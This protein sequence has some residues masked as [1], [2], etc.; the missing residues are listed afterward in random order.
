MLGGEQQAYTVQEFCRAYAIS[1][2]SLYDLWKTGEGPASYKIGRSRR[3]SRR[4]AEAWQQA[5][6]FVTL[7]GVE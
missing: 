1:R 7:A 4:A 5:L 2:K 6:E 3:I